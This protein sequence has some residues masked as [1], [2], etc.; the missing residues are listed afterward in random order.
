M[1]KLKSLKLM[2][3]AVIA[4]CS[5]G[6]L[7]QTSSEKFA[8]TL[9]G[10]KTEA[11][12]TGFAADI[13]TS[14]VVNLEIPA[15]L[16]NG[17]DPSKPYKVVGVAANA[18]T[19]A[20]DATLKVVV[21][22]ITIADENVA[23]IG[24]NAFAGF[25]KVAEVIIGKKVTSIGT[26]AF[27]GDAKLKT[28]TFNAD[29]VVAAI[30]ENAFAGTI[31]EDL[32]LTNTKVTTINNLFGSWYAYD[33]VNW[34]EDADTYN[35]GLTN[36][37]PIDGTTAVSATAAEVYNATLTG[38]TPNAALAA[39]E[40]VFSSEQ[41]TA[42]NTALT[43]AF[44]TSI[45]KTAANVALYNYIVSPATDL[46]AAPGENFT[47][48][49]V[50]SSNA[51]EPLYEARFTAATVKTAANVNKYN[52][53]VATGAI[54]VGATVE[55]AT[56]KTYNLTLDGHVT[57][58][59]V[60]YAKK[61]A[62]PFTSLKSVTLPATWEAT[63]APDANMPGA[64]ENCSAL[65][66]VTFTAP[67]KNDQVQVLNAKAFLGT[68]IENL[69]LT[70]THVKSIPSDLIVDGTM[71]NSTLKTVSF[72]TTLTTINAKAFYQ[73]AQLNSVTF[74]TNSELTAIG[75]FVFGITPSLTSISF[76]NCYKL[77]GFTTT[78]FVRDDAIIKNTE[79][80]TITL[81]DYDKNK[82]GSVKFTAIGTALANL[83]ALTTINNLSDKNVATIV[84]NAFKNDVA[85]E[86]LTFNS[87][88]SSIAAGAFTGCTKLA[89]LSIAGST[90]IAGAVFDNAAKA[91]LTT[92][93]LTGDV[94]G[95]INSAAFANCEKITSL[96]IAKD[97]KYNATVQAGAIAVAEGANIEIGSISQ[98]PAGLIT[99]KGNVASL[100]IGAINVDL[101]GATAIVTGAGKT[102]AEATVGTI[103]ADKG[104]RAD[105][106]GQAEKITFGAI[107][108]ALSATS[109]AN[110]ALKEIVFNGIIKDVANMI[111]AIAFDENKAANLEKVTYEPETAPENGIFNIA[112][113]GTDAKNAAEEVEFVT[114]SEIAV[115]YGVAPANLYRVKY[116]LTVVE[117]TIAVAGPSTYKYGKFFVPNGKTYKIAKSQNGANVV[118]YEAYRDK[119]DKNYIYVNQLRLI[120]GYFYVKGLNSTLEKNGTA[121]IVKSD[122]TDD[123]IATKTLE[124]ENSLN[125]NSAGQPVNEIIYQGE[126]ILG[127]LLKTKTLA[128]ATNNSDFALY[129]MMKT[130]T[131]GL[132]WKQFQSNITMPAYTFYVR[133]DASVAAPELKVIF[134]DGSV[135]EGTTGIQDINAAEQMNG[136]IYNLQGIRV[137]GTQK[138]MYIMNGKK[139][140]Q[141]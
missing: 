5:T 33:A 42:Y 85:L 104:F 14:E 113:F 78:P 30:G 51:G 125:Y 99:A 100:N 38:A 71:V 118:V 54:K 58:T 8:I 101:S 65:A 92:L 26:G 27:S 50:A 102:I 36:A 35:A 48:A 81:P 123:V 77:A 69:T 131:N 13:E 53:L 9:N 25:T 2:L 29:G 136:E 28:V 93:K 39:A 34:G 7:A 11:T 116:S 72:P 107:N 126:S 111:P 88:V 98:T 62:K 64:F 68:A 140:I 114:T 122:K 16:K 137:N 89:E 10:A 83:A 132:Q 22:K 4:L 6:A 73:C 74:P 61:D 120:N 70:N 21:E 86:S 32:N 103:A 112:A 108:S 134:T 117:E 119:E 41:I 63:V 105:V 109:T 82:T 56:A 47:S 124:T 1:K 23:T 20:N 97:K 138:G 139:F 141:K 12:I 15:T 55:A 79:L 52:M 45:E 31:I 121:V 3:F 44:T 129:A 127:S 59:T 43:T 75:N 106:L 130:A 19:G 90:N 67:A 84:E 60:R 135:D 91:A 18:F 95:T 17:E 80:K 128:D 94:T 49:E 96:Q 133:G 76:E 57:A 66:T 40:A 115:L 87:N 37:L 24:N 46:T 110:A